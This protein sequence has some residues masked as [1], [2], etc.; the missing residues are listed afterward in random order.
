VHADAPLRAEYEPCPH[1]AHAAAL[2]ARRADEN[3]PAAHSPE[4]FAAEAAPS[5]AE[6]DP[7]G[8]GTQEPPA[9]APRA[10]E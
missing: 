10:E 4:Q 2:V 3:E 5:A 1:A 7:A 9:P 8:H 6:K